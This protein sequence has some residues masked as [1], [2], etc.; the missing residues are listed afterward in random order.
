MESGNRILSSKTLVITQLVLCVVF[1]FSQHWW[2]HWLSYL[3]LDYC[4]MVQANLAELKLGFPHYYLLVHF[5]SLFLDLG[6]IAFSLYLV[7]RTFRQSIRQNLA[8]MATSV[9]ITLV[10][11]EI[12]LRLLGWVPG[13]FQYN[14]WVKSVDELVEVCGFQADENGVFKVDTSVVRIVREEAKAAPLEA[15]DAALQAV[16]L[17]YAPELLSVYQ[18]H[19]VEYRPDSINSELLRSVSL[20]ANKTALSAYDSVLFHYRN[21]PINQHGFYSI[22][23]KKSSSNLPKVLLLGDSFTWGHSSSNKTY[24]FANTLLARDYLVYNTGISGAD[25]AQYRKILELYLDSLNPNVVAVNFFMENDVEYFD[26]QLRSGIPIHFSTNAGNI[27]GFQAGVQ[28]E[29]KEDAYNNVMRSMII[30]QTS[31]VNKM[32][33]K[34]VVSTLVWSGL[35]SVGV[36]N[37]E[38]FVGLKRPKRPEC[39]YDIIWMENYCASR[40]IPFILSVIP[41][42]KGGKL[43][44]PENVENLFDSITHHQP[45][46]T[47]SMYNA[48]DGHF[49]DAGHLFYANYLQVL[50]HN[51]LSDS[52]GSIK[53]DD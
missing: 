16:N 35:V 1:V 53:A 17:K 37:H 15:N 38:Y 24:S 51:K 7:F 8:L 18:D 14:K 29:T 32:M 10:L 5:G 13:Q 45:N 49:N 33:S 40:N 21:N 50:I 11:A 3:N 47:V 6:L 19:S 44:G 46:M 26:R 23:F 22:P 9:L 31:K 41:K 42:L 52:N 34:T 28:F 12:G 25:V 30:P 43:E 2:C 20:M 4:W 39:N 27:L 36:I 48:K